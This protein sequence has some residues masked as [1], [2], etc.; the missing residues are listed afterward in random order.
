MKIAVNM[1]PIVS[2]LIKILYFIAK[3]LALFLDS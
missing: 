2:L 1:V 3:P